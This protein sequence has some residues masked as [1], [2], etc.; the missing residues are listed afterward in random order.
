MKSMKQNMVCR[1]QAGQITQRNKGL[2]YVQCNR[3]VQRPGAAHP[4]YSSPLPC[5]FFN[6]GG[7]AAATRL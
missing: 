2:M 3:A 6:P 4:A 1:R 7:C 5:Y